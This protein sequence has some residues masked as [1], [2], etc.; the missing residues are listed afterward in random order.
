MGAAMQFAERILEF[1][2]RYTTLYCYG[3]GVYAVAVLRFLEAQSIFPK[4]C[5]VSDVVEPDAA[6]MGVPVARFSD[7]VLEEDAGVILALDEKWHV[8]LTTALEKRGL[9]RRHIHCPTIAEINAIRIWEGVML[10]PA[11]NGQSKDEAAYETRYQQLLCQFARI[12]VRMVGIGAVG[13]ALHELFY[14]KRYGFQ[15]NNTYYLF[16]L[17]GGGEHPWENTFG[18]PNAFLYEAFYDT[19][20]SAVNKENLPFWNYVFTHHMESVDINGAWSYDFVIMDSIHKMHTGDFVGN[21]RTTLSLAHVEKLGE[22][23][24]KQM[25]VQNTF[26]LFFARDAVYYQQTWNGI[27]DDPLR[28]MDKYRNSD[29]AS[30]KK[31]A[32]Y[33]IEKGISAVRI[34][35]TPIPD[36]DMGNIIDYAGEFHTDAMDFY[37]AKHCK[38]YVGDHSGAM[39]FTVYWDRPMVMINLPVITGF[40]DGTFPFDHRRDLGIYHKFYSKR[41]KRLLNLSELLVIEDCSHEIPIYS[42][43]INVMMK[44]YEHEIV[45]IANT[46]DEILAVTQ[47]MEERLQGDMEYTEEDEHLQMRYRAILSPYLEARPDTFFCDV[48]IGR[49]FLRQNLWLTR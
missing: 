17:L 19:Q 39:F 37:L 48:R 26:V 1:A 7:V 40:Y 25:G 29:I 3:A 47:E 43:T 16:V 20:F 10:H 18:K 2:E 45:S 30:M 34:G 4:A 5:L 42:G 35:A 8:D 23:Q 32:D 15:E 24:L 28:I 31:T 13:T 22:E 49:D 14:H 6:C 27:I 9:A 44:Y 11:G 33:L 46:E 38:F 21:G 41:K 36:K 12:E